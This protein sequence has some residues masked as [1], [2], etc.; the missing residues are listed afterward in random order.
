MDL[1]GRKAES[2]GGLAN[3]L[4]RSP[5]KGLAVGTQLTE[6]LPSPLLGNHYGGRSEAIHP[7]GSSQPMV[8]QG[9]VPTARPFRPS[10][11]SPYGRFGSG[12]P[13]RSGRGFLRTPLP[14]QGLLT[15]VFSP[16]HTEVLRHVCALLPLSPSQ[17]C[18]PI[19]IL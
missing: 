18:P 1:R 11:W 10:A 3:T 17:A 12:T 14:P 16:S 8:E 15:Q 13:P 9:T 6:L 19:N 4:R 7:T 5:S 2:C